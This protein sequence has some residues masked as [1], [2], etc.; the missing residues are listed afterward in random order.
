MDLR[1]KNVGNSKTRLIVLG[2]ALLLSGCA[3]NTKPPAGNLPSVDHILLEVSDI[4]ASIAFYHNF[5][6]LPVESD[7]GHFV[8]LAAGN[9]RIALWDKRWDW[10]T[11]GTKC[12]RPGWGMYP[13]LKVPD[14]TEMVNRAR[15]QGYKIIQRPRHYYWGME[16][17]IAD[18]DG[19]IWALV[20]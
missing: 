20:D 16:A 12:E 15:K 7:N 10:E 13:H 8:M 9:M 6:G 18:P 4:N 5:M 3:E 14:V 11:P 1:L 2:I 19:Y 17:F